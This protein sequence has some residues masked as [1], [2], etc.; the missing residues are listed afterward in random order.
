M[1]AAMLLVVI[2]VSVITLILFAPR[3]GTALG[4]NG[5]ARLRDYLSQQI[6]AIV[7]THLEPQLSFQTLDY[8]AP[9]TV[10]LT[11]VSLT[12]P[13][14]TRV[15]EVDRLL[16]QLAEIPTV[17]KPL[18]IARVGVE[19]GRVRL[20]QDPATG[21]FLGFSRFTKVHTRADLE[22]V[23]EPQRLS[24]VLVLE[25]VALTD[26]QLV[27]DD[28]SGDPMTLEGLTCTLDIHPAADGPGWYELDAQAGRTPGLA[29][30]LRGSFNI[31]EMILQLAEATAGIQVDA[32]TIESLPPPIQNVLR[33]MDAAGR[34][35]LSFQGR[36]P[37]LTLAQADVAGSLVLQGFNIALADYRLPIRRLDARVHLSDSRLA[38]S[39]LRAEALNGI[40]TAH[41]E[42]DLS[43]PGTPAL[44]EWTLDRLDLREA[45]RAGL[46]EG[47]VPK[48]A[49]KLSGHGSAALSLE[50]PL[51]TIDGIGEVHIRE[52]RLLVFPG[53]AQIVQQIGNLDLSGDS[54]YGHE[55]DIRF[56]LEPPGVRITESSL[57]TGLLAADAHGLVGYDGS[58]DLSVRA[59]PLKKLA[60]SLGLIGRAIG[61]LT[62]RLVSYH[63][64]G[65]INNTSV[66][67]RP[68]GLGG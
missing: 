10:R 28:G 11:D 14:G 62:E 26:L 59:G 27:Y 42:A 13:D 3:G 5:A 8:E 7:N 64:Q 53:Y 20:I 48:L 21:G 38:V 54:S 46:S 4:L 58:L 24:S 67:V 33:A 43:K 35:D 18:R 37:L 50:Q 47:E 39:E 16:V 9:G 25:R 49:G 22:A 19:A 23:P 57:V 52:G 65:T 34:M 17:G 51:D 61:S 60:K 36:I 2:G 6:V 45:L 44:A 66:T 30:R 55:A 15:L 40:V 63:V 56:R 41:V 31:D 68:F 1:L 32:G 29:A 12:A